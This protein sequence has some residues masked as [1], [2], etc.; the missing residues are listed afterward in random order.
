MKYDVKI[1]WHRR[2]TERTERGGGGGALNS[3][4]QING[5]KNKTKTNK[6]SNLGKG[7]RL[8][9]PNIQGDEWEN[10]STRGNPLAGCREN[11][12]IFMN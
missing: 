6:K 8:P 12:M 11:P 1:K 9:V 4:I 10:Q 5:L 3:G 2:V 7:R